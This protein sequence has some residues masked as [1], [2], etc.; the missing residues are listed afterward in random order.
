MN[1]KKLYHHALILTI[2]TIVYNII[3]GV[4]SVF[5]GAGDETLVLFGF[6]L[7]SFIEVISAVG[8][9][10]ML[11]RMH[12]RGTYNAVSRDTFERQAL[13]VTGTAFYLLTIGLVSGAAISIIAKNTPQTTIPGIVISLLSIATM[14]IL[15][16][17]KL[18]A[19]KKLDSDAIIADAHCTKACFSLSFVVLLSSLL[20]ELSGFRWLDSI[21]S[22]GIAWFAF[23]EGREA[24]EK[25]RTNSLKCKCNSD[26]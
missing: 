7:D 20:Y 15:M 21:G 24:F 4:V 18:T 23:S 2:V 19:G 8:I 3:E 22:L 16:K 11:L 17:L 26:T 13:K 1:T 12:K 25:A 10:H 6:G 9:L 5:F 14:F